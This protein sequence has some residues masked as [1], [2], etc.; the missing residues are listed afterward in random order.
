MILRPVRLLLLDE[1]YT[2]FDEDGVARVNELLTQVRERG[3]SAI[4]IT[5][6]LERARRVI[7]RTVRL[8]AGV[9]V[10]PSLTPTGAMPAFRMTSNG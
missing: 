1:P 3:G 6:D 9:L 5:H 4:V 10:E 7:D 2:S 8:D